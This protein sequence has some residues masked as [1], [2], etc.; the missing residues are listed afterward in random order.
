MF[1]SELAKI[2]AAVEAINSISLSP[3]FSSPRTAEKSSRCGHVY[4]ICSYRV[5][6][7][8]SCKFTRDKIGGKFENISSLIALLYFFMHVNFM[9]KVSKKLLFLAFKGAKIDL[10]LFTNYLTHPVSTFN[11]FL[12]ICVSVDI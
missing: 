12:P 8:Q 7:R 3:I 6:K 2:A 10:S 9:Y 1:S 5:L 11:R 4:K